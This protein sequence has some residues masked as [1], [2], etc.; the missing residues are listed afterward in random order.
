MRNAVRSVSVVLAAGVVWLGAC[1]SD[2]SDG[3]VSTVTRDGM[4]D[5]A[6]AT[7]VPV[8]GSEPAT[9]PVGPTGDTGSDPGFIV[10]AAEFTGWERRG[11]DGCT[12]LRG[13]IADPD[14]DGLIVVQVTGTTCQPGAALNGNYGNYRTEADVRADASDAV[15][16]PV[17]AG[18]AFVQTYTECTNG[19]TD[20]VQPVVLVT[21]DVPADPEHP[22]VTLIG[23]GDVTADQVAA[24]A[25]GLQPA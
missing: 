2:D 8:G 11:T 25:A 7:T 15:V 17:G 3:G 10:T 13:Q 1:S 4:R 5:V 20:F 19:C 9:I 6:A 24:A 18:I 23:V 14:G 12:E 21:L 22:T 16:T